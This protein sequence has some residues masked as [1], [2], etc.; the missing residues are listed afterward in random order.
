[1]NKSKSYFLLLLIFAFISLA[2]NNTKQEMNIPQVTPEIE[3][4]EI[5]NTNTY[6]SE[7]FPDLEIKYLSNWD[8]NEKIED[9]ENLIDAKNLVLDFKKEGYLL[10]IKVTTVPP[11]G[12]EPY[13]YKEDEIEYV[14]LGEDYARVTDEKGFSYGYLYDK[15]NNLQ[16]FNDI[17][18]FDNLNPEE[19]IAC[20][21]TN[22]LKSTTTN[23]LDKDFNT[24][25]K[26]GAVIGAFLFE[27][28]DKNEEII[29][30]ADLIILSL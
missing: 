30:E 19:Y 10:Q 24:Q 4:P 17:I 7:F 1:M 3:L 23:F 21:D 6:T 14:K 29:K 12:F 5:I 15:T 28:K 8:L 9:S 27:E 13:C 18:N 22:L 2:C 26:F 11:M 25:E 20:G 16:S